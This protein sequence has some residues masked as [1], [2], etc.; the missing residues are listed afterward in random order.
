M[1]RCW[2]QVSSE[3]T[4]AVARGSSHRTTTAVQNA[5]KPQPAARWQV[6]QLTCCALEGVGLNESWKLMPLER[7]ICPAADEHFPGAL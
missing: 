2:T 6:G 4:Q 3:V 1:E 7:F 5:T